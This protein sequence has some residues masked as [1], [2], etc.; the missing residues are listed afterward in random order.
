MRA[1]A[2]MSAPDFFPPS[3]GRA[4]AENRSAYGARHRSSMCGRA[5]EDAPEG[6][7]T[8]PI[9]VAVADEQFRAVLEHQASAIVIPLSSTGPAASQ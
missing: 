9:V 4:C 1:Q 8:T 2:G 7:R 3:I 6:D 5:G